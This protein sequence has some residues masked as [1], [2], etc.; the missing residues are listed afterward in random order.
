MAYLARIS[1]S[2]VTLTCVFALSGCGEDYNDRVS[3]T[4][5]EDCGFPTD[6][7]DRECCGGFCM[8]AIGGGGSGC[9]SGYRYITSEPGFG[10]CVVAPMCPVQPDMSVPI[11]MSKVD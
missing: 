11:D 7:T 10:D 3:C 4:T 2:L 6:M 9:D 8:A 1:M 5:A